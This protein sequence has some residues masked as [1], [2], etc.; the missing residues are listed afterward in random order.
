MER[1]DE[2]FLTAVKSVGKLGGFTLKKIATSDDMVLRSV[3]ITVTRPSSGVIQDDL[4]D[5]DNE[6][7]KY[8]VD[9]RGQVETERE[10]DP[11]EEV[12]D[13]KAADSADRKNWPEPVHGAEYTDQGTLTDWIYQDGRGWVEKSELA[14][15]NGAKPEEAE[16]AK[17]ENEPL[18][19]HSGRRR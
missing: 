8:N 14:K 2:L 17:V 15:Q 4:F 9:D 12:Q 5:I 3:T 16:V 6:G 19:L 11:D 10:S 1:S 7:I 18:P 13:T